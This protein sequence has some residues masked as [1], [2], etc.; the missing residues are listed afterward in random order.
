MIPVRPVEHDSERGCAH[1]SPAARTEPRAG[2]GELDSSSPTET[3]VAASGLS[4]AA[5]AN[6]PT[7]PNATR[8]PTARP[9]FS[10][11][12]RIDW[13]TLL[14]RTYRED[15]LACPC[16]GKVRFVALVTEP[17]TAEAILRSMGPPADPPPVAK[18]RSPSFDPDPEPPDW[19]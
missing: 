8:N 19:D 18:A 4:A 9:R 6:E 11:P 5:K 12:W 2:S 16:G 14:K 15:V 7:E 17:E 3:A 13:A 10:A 1:G